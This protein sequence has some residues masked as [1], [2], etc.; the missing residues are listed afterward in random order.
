MVDNGPNGYCLH[1]QI[2]V[3]GIWLNAQCPICIN[4]LVPQ[5][6]SSVSVIE[7]TYEKF[8]RLSDLHYKEITM[9]SSRAVFLKEVVKCRLELIE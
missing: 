1:C 7:E 3:V 6:S 8:A 9:I 4:L 5:V 2:T